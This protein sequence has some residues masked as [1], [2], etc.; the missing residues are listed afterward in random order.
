[1][2]Q[3]AQTLAVQKGHL[4]TNGVEKTLRGLWL[5]TSVAAPTPPPPPNLTSPTPP[6]TLIPQKPSIISSVSSALLVTQQYLFNNCVSTTVFS[7]NQ[8]ILTN[9]D[10]HMK[11][12]V[13]A[14]Y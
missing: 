12:E 2:P 6:P 7:G 4:T 1:M 10:S 9:Y 13:E 5:Y 11:V 8:V 14:V 3:A